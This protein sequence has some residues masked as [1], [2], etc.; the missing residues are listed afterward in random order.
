MHFVHSHVFLLRDHIERMRKSKATESEV[1]LFQRKMNVAMDCVVNDSLVN[2]YGFEKVLDEEPSV[3]GKVKIF[4]GKETVGVDCDDL[5]AY[6]VYYM[7][8]DDKFQQPD[9]GVE[10]HDMWGSF[11]EADGS[12]KKDFADAIKKFVDDH[13]QNSS[14]SD[15]ELQK[16]H[17]M[18]KTMKESSDRNVSQAGNAIVGSKRTVDGTD[19][20]SINWS[21]ILYKFVDT[22]KPEDVWSKPNRKLIPNY[23]DII[24]PSWKDREKEKIFCAIDSSGSIDYNA[25]SLFISVLRN[26]PKRFE[27]EAISFDTACYEY[28]LFGKDQ[29]R[30]GGGTNFQIIEDY[31]QKNCKKY[32]V[33]V[34]VLTDGMGTPVAPEFPK[35]WGWLLY[36]PCQEHYCA[37]MK[38]YK[39]KDL[40]VKR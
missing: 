13:I 8:P 40:L 17:D 28:D 21:K 36:G 24:L 33:A 31:I 2:L 1:A 35:R 23:P 27:I 22:L 29:P 6:E 9:D 4:Y 7:L 3:N 14:F 10:N 34:F 38:T 5:T 39:I 20:R 16:I 18:K 32:P 25:L 19:R 26:T 37:T 11:Y 15:E 30:G 12:V